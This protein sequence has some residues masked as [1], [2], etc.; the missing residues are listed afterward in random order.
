MEYQCQPDISRVTG[1][2]AKCQSNC[3]KYDENVNAST[4]SYKASY[5]NL[6]SVDAV[7]KSLVQDNILVIA[8]IEGKNLL[9]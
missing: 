5:T 6:T 1:Y 7:K 4:T 8:M 9:I 3:L 2:K